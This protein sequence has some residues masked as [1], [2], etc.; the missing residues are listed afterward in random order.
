MLHEDRPTIDELQHYG[1]LGMKW[2]KRKSTGQ[3]IRTARGSVR[4]GHR[5]LKGQRKKIRAS[6]TESG[7]AKEKATY[8]KMKT[9]FLKNPDRV[10][11]LKMSKGE[12]AVNLLMGNRYTVGAAVA[13]SAGRRRIAYKQ[14]TGAYDKK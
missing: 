6:T 10:T 2:G 5:E 3:E 12:I 9:S 7:K 4:R 8:A 13:T 11:A 14:K 1:K